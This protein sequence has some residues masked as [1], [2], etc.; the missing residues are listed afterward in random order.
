M[1]ASLLK[2]YQTH[3]LGEQGDRA[4][5]GT[6]TLH[7]QGALDGGRQFNNWSE[8]QKRESWLVEGATVWGGKGCGVQAQTQGLASMVRPGPSQQPCLGPVPGGRGDMVWPSH[9]CGCPHSAGHTGRARELDSEKTGPSLL[10][11]LNLFPFYN[12]GT[13]LILALPPLWGCCGSPWARGG[14]GDGGLWPPQGTGHHSPSFL[15]R[16]QGPAQSRHSWSPLVSD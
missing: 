13:F 1:F 7:T 10:V 12:I 16:P 14:V 15:L 3:S 9:L 5:L 8:S 2:K 6:W 11:S 4:R